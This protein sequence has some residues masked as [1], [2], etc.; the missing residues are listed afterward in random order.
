MFRTKFCY[1]KDMNR[2]F[3]ENIIINVD[4]LSSEED[5]IVIKLNNS[6]I[7]FMASYLRN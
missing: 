1:Y 6:K 2:H 5:A 4:R 7:Q 3:R